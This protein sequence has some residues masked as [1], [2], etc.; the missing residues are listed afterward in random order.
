M[1]PRVSSFFGVFLI[2][3]SISMVGLSASEPAVATEFVGGL[4]FASAITADAQGNIYV[5]DGTADGSDAPGRIL[6]YDSSGRLLL[7]IGAWGGG[8]LLNYV[9]GVTVGDDGTIYAVNEGLFFRQ[10]ESFDSNGA[11][12]ASYG[13]AGSTCGGLGIN[14]NANLVATGSTLYLVSGSRCVQKWTTSGVFTSTWGSDGTSAGQFANPTGIA[15]DGSGDVYVADLKNRVQRFTSAGS[16]VLQWGNEILN[17]VNSPS[18]ALSG[19]SL[20]VGYNSGLSAACGH[21]VERRTLTGTLVGSSCLPWAGGNTGIAVNGSGDVFVTDGTRIIK[22]SGH[23]TAVITEPSSTVLAGR[24]TTLSASQ[25]E[26]PFSTVS[27]YAWDLDGDGTY[28]QSTGTT[29]Q[30]LA[31]FPRPGNQTVG[32]RVTSADN[33]VATTSRMIDVAADAVQGRLV[34]DTGAVSTGVVLTGREVRLDARG[35]TTQA[36]LDGGC[37][38][39]IDSPGFATTTCSSTVTRFEWDLDGDETFETPGGAIATIPPFGTA[40]T[41][42]AAVRLTSR[43]GSTGVATVN[44]EVRL[45]PPTEDTGA[46]INGGAQ[47]TNTPNVSVTLSWPAFATLA[48]LSNDGG[49]GGAASRELAATVAWRLDSSGPER[50][51]KTIYVRFRGAGDDT[52]TF[53]DDIILDETAPVIAGAS[54][55]SSAAAQAAA[56]SRTYRIKVRASDKTSGVASA[57]FA[58]DKSKKKLSKAQKYSATLT[59]KATSKPLWVR[60]Q[61]RAGNFSKWKKLP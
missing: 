39:L 51:P 33:Q 35:S 31:T 13:S 52:K 14:D 48:R 53:Q 61:D 38:S 3:A 17:S 26:A 29:P 12:V 36:G 34:V 2:L 21:L 22:Q 54:V 45:A 60:V 46:S 32:L 49:F 28:E 8:Q 43:G 25:S 23:T 56:K 27:N 57:Q 19:N 18:L 47:F 10:I 44:F 4:R 30:V 5:A 41:K 11:Y 42:S 58:T 20:Y 55:A 7:T 6:K 15:V 40:G 37:S 59:F 1:A 16:F 9:T 50:L 24:A